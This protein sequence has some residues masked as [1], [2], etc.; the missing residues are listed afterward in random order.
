MARPRT[1]YMRRDGVPN[2][3]A[4]RRFGVR[5]VY[6]RRGRVACASVAPGARR[7]ARTIRREVERRARCDRR[8]SFRAN[9]PVEKP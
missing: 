5:I 1:S 4:S 3:T 9:R 8:V 2:R 6:C 7:K